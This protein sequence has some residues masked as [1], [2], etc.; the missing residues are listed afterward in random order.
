MTP[1]V[2]VCS[3]DYHP[4]EQGLNVE[5]PQILR[6]RLDEIVEKLHVR[7][8]LGMDELQILLAPGVR[9]LLTRRSV[10][11]VESAVRRV[12]SEM[13][14]Q[15]W[16][17]R[18]DSSEALL[19]TAYAALN[20]IL[21]SGAFFFDTQPVKITG[22]ESL[23][24]MNELEVEALRQCYVQ[25]QPRKK[26]CNQLGVSESAFSALRARVIRGLKRSSIARDLQERPAGP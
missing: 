9:L 16:R 8:P 2:P 11:S 10:K 19:A 22:D 26:V 5:D 13:A 20:T 14:I 17:E 21:S 23:A 24:E 18:P 6:A 3:S 12:L 4:F 7:D 15:I 25:A 1:N